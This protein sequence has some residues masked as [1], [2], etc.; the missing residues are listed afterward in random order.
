[1]RE[2]FRQFDLYESG[3]SAVSAS[4]STQKLDVY[5]V[6]ASNMSGAALYIQ[7][8]NTGSLPVNGN[9]PRRS[10]RVDGNSVLKLSW[11]EGREYHRGLSFAWSN[12]Y[13]TLATGSFTQVSVDVDY[14]TGY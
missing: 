4:V 13:A 11:R 12:A 6:I 14:K 9:V 3:L 7:L 2:K 5:E 1:M 10:Y 8:F